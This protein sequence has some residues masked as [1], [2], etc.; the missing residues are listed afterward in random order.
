[1]AENKCDNNGFKKGQ[2]T[3]KVADHENRLSKIDEVLEKIR[4]RPPVWCTI[5]FGI[6]LAAV[7]WLSH[8][9][10]ALIK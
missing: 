2:L 9:A 10:V 7:G 8:V 3:Q 1:M 6:L 5:V 4:N